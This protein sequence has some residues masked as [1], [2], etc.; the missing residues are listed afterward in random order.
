MA[1]FGSIGSTAVK[2]VAWRRSPWRLALCVWLLLVAIS[3]AF[4]WHLRHESLGAQEREL[5]LLSAA[6]TDDID[7]GL[8]GAEEGLHA[9]RSE[10]RDGRL[11]QVGAEARRALHTRADLMPLIE[12]IWL[13]G[14]RG[15]VLA[16]SDATPVP[17]L[18][19]FAPPLDGLGEDAMAVSRPFVDP[20]SSQSFVALA[21]RFDAA[22]G[23]VAGWIV[24]GLPATVLLGAF[25]ARGVGLTV[26]RYEGAPE[27]GTRVSEGYR[28]APC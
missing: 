13:I 26:H 15:Q 27:V 2:A 12:R 14:P 20:L 11:P 21:M 16:D 3:A 24:A 28:R 6:L 8:R 19:T 7:R 23:T 22:D 4:L 9:V 10:L 1:A 25:A 17:D 18:D 5:I